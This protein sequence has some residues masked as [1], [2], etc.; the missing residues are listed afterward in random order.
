MAVGLKVGH[1]D[2]AENITTEGLDLASLKIGTR[3]IAG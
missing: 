1:G 3:L 2:F